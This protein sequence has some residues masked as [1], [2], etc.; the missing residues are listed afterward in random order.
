MLSMFVIMR[1]ITWKSTPPFFDGNQGSCSEVITLNLNETVQS[2][3]LSTRSVP[4][5]VKQPFEQELEILIDKKVLARL[6][7]LTN[8][9]SQM[10]R[11]TKNSEI[12]IAAS[13]Q[14]Y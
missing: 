4:C 14:E 6:E 9:T 5:L 12:H 8:W 3:T 11:V 10:V 13:V 1:S 2:M 7:E